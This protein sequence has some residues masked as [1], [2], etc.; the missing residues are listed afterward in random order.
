MSDLTEFL[1]ARIDEDEAVARAMIE[2]DDGDDTGLEG[3]FD[4]LTT[5]GAPGR[6]FVPRDAA[7]CHSRVPEWASAIRHA[8][9]HPGRFA[10]SRGRSA[11]TP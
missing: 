6:S 2:D 10:R 1:L 7:R 4:D 11:A 8:L 5:P 3:M 9:R